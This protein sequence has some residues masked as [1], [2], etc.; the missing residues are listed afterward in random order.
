MLNLSITQRRT[1]FKVPKIFSQRNEHSELKKEKGSWVHRNYKYNIK[2][3]NR[4]HL[5]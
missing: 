4:F 2:K 1:Q 5:I 3:M